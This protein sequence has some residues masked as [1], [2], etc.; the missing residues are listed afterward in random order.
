MDVATLNL[1]ADMV[2]ASCRDKILTFDVTDKS[3]GT[4][5]LHTTHEFVGAGIT[6]DVVLERKSGA[7]YITFTG[8]GWKVK[9]YAMDAISRVRYNTDEALINRNFIYYNENEYLT[10]RKAEVLGGDPSEA[11]TTLLLFKH[12]WFVQDGY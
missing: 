10:F 6:L 8:E 1:L 4:S 3:F 7:R 11:L 9:V 12:K 2:V 5:S